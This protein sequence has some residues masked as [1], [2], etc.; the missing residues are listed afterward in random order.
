MKWFRRKKRKQKIA[1]GSLGTIKTI[2]GRRQ[3]SSSEDPTEVRSK[4]M[5]STSEG[6][7]NL[8]YLGRVDKGETSVPANEHSKSCLTWMNEHRLGCVCGYYERGYG[9]D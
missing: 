2:E 7:G 8:G 1:K 9:D 3:S 5:I 4:Y 6:S